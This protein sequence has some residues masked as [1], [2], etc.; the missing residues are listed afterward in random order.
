MF[1][2]AL[3]ALE[4]HAAPEVE[5]AYARARELCEQVT[6][7]PRLFPVLVALGWF[8]LMRGPAAAA[9]DVGTRLAAMAEATRDPAVQLAAHT[10]LGLVSFYLGDFEGALDHS[11][12]GLA[13]YDPASHSSADSPA[14]RAN[15]DPGVSCTGHSAWALWVLGYPAQAAARMRDALALADSIAHPFTIAQSYRFGAAFHLS[16]R[17]RDAA[18]KHTGVSFALATEHGFGAVLK[19]AGFHQGW[20]AA[21]RDGRETGLEAMHEWLTVCRAIRAAMLTPAYL[22][23]LAEVYGKLGRPA[24]G[25]AL[26]EDALAGETDSGYRYWSAELHR[27]KGTLILQRGGKDASVE[28]RAESCFLEA[29]Q[30]ARRQRA[31]LFE[32]RAAMSVSQLWATERRRE[33]GRALLSEVYGWFSEGF[34]TADLTEAKARLE[35]L[36]QP[37]SVSE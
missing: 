30:I 20:L 28:K 7:S 36:Q 24:E 12:R 10:V 13:L 25:L 3:T 33:E 19:A 21:E 26:V 15:V 6:D 35:E 5:T 4:G 27:V 29:L 17:E 2:S 1:G 37:R 32:L 23:W 11:Q 34:D 9:R 22:A 31:K 14:F 8:S 18:Q 16:R